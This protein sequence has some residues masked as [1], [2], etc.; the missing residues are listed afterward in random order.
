MYFCVFCRRAAIGAQ[1]RGE[2]TDAAFEGER[3]MSAPRYGL[4]PPSSLTSLKMSDRIYLSIRMY[5]PVYLII[6]GRVSRA[7][8]CW[9]AAAAGGARLP[10][11]ADSSREEMERTGVA[12]ETRQTHRKPRLGSFPPSPPSLL[13]QV[14]ESCHARI[15]RGEGWEEPVSWQNW[16]CLVDVS[17]GAGAGVDLISKINLKI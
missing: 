11:A 12:P 3:E 14:T 7:E 16:V 10:N 6:W 15:R 9:E 13:Q 5:S 17:G 2:E 1:R 8:C 4:H